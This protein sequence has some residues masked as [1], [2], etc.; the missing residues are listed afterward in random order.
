[1]EILDDYYFGLGLVVYMEKNKAH[2]IY[3]QYSLKKSSKSIVL[4]DY[5]EISGR[6]E[7]FLKLIDI[8]FYSNL[9]STSFPGY[10]AREP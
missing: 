8:E 5:I 3:I 1:M 6:M 2:F 7:S 9:F 10:G 4:G